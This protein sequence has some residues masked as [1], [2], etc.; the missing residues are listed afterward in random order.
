MLPNNLIFFQ[1]ITPI[2]MMMHD[3]DDLI[4]HHFLSLYALPHQ[5][6]EQTKV[7]MFNSFNFAFLST[8]KHIFVEHML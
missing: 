1:C 5:R 4:L 6:Y 8:Q 2:S 7:H 3:V